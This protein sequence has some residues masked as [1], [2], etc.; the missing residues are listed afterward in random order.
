LSEN[1]WIFPKNRSNLL[2]HIQ[3]DLIDFNAAATH[4]VQR[5]DGLHLDIEPHGLPGWRAMEPSAR[6]TCLLQLRDT[7][8][9]V[10]VY[11]NGHGAADVPVYADLPVWYDQVP[12]PVGWDSD[13]ERD[14]WFAAL[15][16]SLAGISL[17]AYERNTAARIESGV[18][19]ELQHFAGETRIGLE[20]SAGAGKTWPA[21]GDLV[22]MVRTEE[23]AG[24]PPRPVDVH[25]FVQFHDL[26]NP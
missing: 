12:K 8:Q 13:A 7:F 17:M 2:S 11:L 1:T 20:A 15:G 25:D 4:A 14:A 23:A 16:Q 6:K 22:E 9:A 21:F 10:R 5:Y 19:W 24:S 3:E 18:A 26:A